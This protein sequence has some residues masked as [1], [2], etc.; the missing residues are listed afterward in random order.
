MTSVYL[1]FKTAPDQHWAIGVQDKCALLSLILNLQSVFHR[2]ETENLRPTSWDRLGHAVQVYCNRPSRA[3]A[4]VVRQCQ[5][6]LSP[7]ATIN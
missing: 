6:T 5:A 4:N 2:L 3:G 7:Y 1:A